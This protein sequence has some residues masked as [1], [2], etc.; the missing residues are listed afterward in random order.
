MQDLLLLIG[1]SIVNLS[2]KFI[3]D[4]KSLDEIKTDQITDKCVKSWTNFSWQDEPWIEFATLK[5]AACH[6]T[7]LLRSIAIWPNLELKTCPKQLL[8]FLPLVIA[9][10]SEEQKLSMP[11]VNLQ[12]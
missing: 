3:Q 11:G 12:L 2:R 4:C 5:V 8:G 9:L 10:P 6:A 7:H 1:P